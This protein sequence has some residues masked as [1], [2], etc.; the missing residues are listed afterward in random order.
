CHAIAKAVDL[1]VVMPAGEYSLLRTESVPLLDL[2]LEKNI[3]WI[4]AAP[5]NSGILATGP[6]ADAY[7]AMRP[8]TPDV[9]AQTGRL[10][11][12]C[13]R[14]GVSLAAAALQFPLRHQAIGS[15]V[16]GAKS[17]EEFAQNMALFNQ[18]L[19][20]AFWREME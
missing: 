15:I 14:H 6:S 12:I 8:A 3:A 1:D 19:P 4:A 9:L 10:S 16:F 17:P 20:E 5:F 7:Y 18:S 2:C 13:G 11:E